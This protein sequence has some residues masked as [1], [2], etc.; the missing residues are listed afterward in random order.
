MPSREFQEKLCRVREL[1]QHEGLGAVLLTTQAGFSWMTCGARN[2]VSIASTKGCSKILITADKT[3]L[4]CSWIELYRMRDEEVK[5]LPIECIGFDWFD[6]DKEDQA[7]KEI[8]G[9]AVIGAD[10]AHPLAR[11]IAKQLS[12]LRY[13][14]TNEEVERYQVLGERAE[15][16]IRCTALSLKPG[17][18]EN[19][20][21]G[22]LSHQA[23]SRHL[24][25]VLALIAVDDRIASY[26]HPIPTEKTLQKTA[27][28]VLCAKYG[29]LIASVS[30]MVC[31]GKI[32]VDLA[33]RHEAVVY[34]DSVFIHE[35]KIS[36]PYSAIFEKGVE[37]Y[38]AVGFPDEWKLHH[39]G[40]ATGYEGR[41]FKGSFTSHQT[42]QP[43]QAVAWNPSITGTKSEDTLICTEAGN[44]L[45]TH[46]RDWQMMSVPVSG[47]EIQRPS[48][49][50]L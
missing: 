15:E 3:Y 16:A 50:C 49:L 19:D 11:N 36:V 34:V 4:L 46:A 6:P 47:T 42:V 29:G 40:G 38:R 9:D 21:A 27:L 12:A 14:L 26:R 2:H 18:T 22:L 48:I 23:Y 1:M 39:Q 17:Q 24:V 13:S 35:T 25:P 37:A 5:S 32:S 7:I 30:R 28:L 33:K 41:D 20:I 44:V 31:F 43:N 45:V 8:V 10:D